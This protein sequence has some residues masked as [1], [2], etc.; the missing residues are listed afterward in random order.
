[1]TRI[2]FAHRA[3]I[4]LDD[5]D[6]YLTAE[7]GSRRAKLVLARIRDR[8]AL[9]Q[10]HPEAGPEREEYGGRRILVCRPYVAIYTIRRLP[11]DTIVVV[12]RIVHGARDI[13]RLLTDE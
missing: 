9:L 2:E 10:E 6:R 7:A 13:P 11:Q 8:I 12:L 4:D 5:I 1:M 3:S